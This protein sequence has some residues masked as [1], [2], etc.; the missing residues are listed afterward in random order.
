MENIELMAINKYMEF[1][2]R[3]YKENTPKEAHNFM[4]C[5]PKFKKHI[6]A[7]KLFYAVCQLTQ[8]H[9]GK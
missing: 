4:E 8:Q 1:L 9:K 7:F 3:T 6:T 2:K 5:F